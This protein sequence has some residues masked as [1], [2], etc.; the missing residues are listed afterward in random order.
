M[1]IQELK[2]ENYSVIQIPQ[3]TNS[4][5]FH[6]IPDELLEN[7]ALV[8]NHLEN[9]NYEVIIMFNDETSKIEKVKEIIQQ[10]AEAL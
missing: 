1:L 8:T 9:K 7:E 4:M 3:E 6:I 10:H 2:G 5:K